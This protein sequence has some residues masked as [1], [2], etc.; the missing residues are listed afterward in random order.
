MKTQ[1]MT[2]LSVIALFTVISAN[3]E[4]KTPANTTAAPAASGTTAAKTTAPATNT[5]APTTSAA[6]PAT[7]GET[8]TITCPPKAGVKTYGDGKWEGVDHA[9]A[10]PFK[11]NRVDGNWIGCTYAGPQGFNFDLSPNGG[12]YKDCVAKPKGV[13]ECKKAN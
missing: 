3:A 9:N 1:L 13:F 5:T 8:I 6:K 4:T 2:A 10:Y 11:S 12:G 7:A